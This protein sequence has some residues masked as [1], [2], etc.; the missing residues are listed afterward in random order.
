MLPMYC[1]RVLSSA[2][3]R[4]SVSFEVT[5]ALYSGNEANASCGEEPAR[6]TS[7]RIE[8]HRVPASG[9]PTRP[10][11]AESCSARESNPFCHP[12]L[13]PKNLP[14]PKNPATLSPHPWFCF[15]FTTSPMPLTPDIVPPRMDPFLLAQ[16]LPL[17]SAFTSP[18]VLM[19][20]AAPSGF[21]SALIPDVAPSAIPPSRPPAAAASP[22]MPRSDPIRPFAAPWALPIFFVDVSRPALSPPR[23]RC[24]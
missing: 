6:C 7:A 1:S 22:P 23:P 2:L 9:V 8:F 19:L 18:P 14:S 10:A 3:M 20:F 11:S 21:R 17:N 16:S 5:A 13:Y 24:P 12:S 4:F 15:L